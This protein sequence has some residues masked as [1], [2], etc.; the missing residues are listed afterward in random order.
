MADEADRT[1]ERLELEDQ[2]LKQYRRAEPPSVGTGIC[3]NCGEKIGKEMRWCDSH[4]R[5]DYEH[6]S[7]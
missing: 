6:R 7:K 3:L 1:Q 2:I 4:C 5:D